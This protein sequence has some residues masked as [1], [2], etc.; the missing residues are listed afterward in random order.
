P[1]T[2]SSG[3]MYGG[4]SRRAASRS[5]AT[6]GSPRST[7]RSGIP[8][9]TSSSTIAGGIRS[10]ATA[11]SASSAATGTSTGQPASPSHD[12]RS[13]PSRAVPWSSIRDVIVSGPTQ[14]I[15]AGQSS[16]PSVSTTSSIATSAPRAIWAAGPRSD[17]TG[18]ASVTAAP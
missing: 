6:P 18:S 10:G 8:P 15:R 3:P 7:V 17:G 5:Y 4:R 1:A 12:G 16:T 11:R 14:V 9:A 13:R 2:G